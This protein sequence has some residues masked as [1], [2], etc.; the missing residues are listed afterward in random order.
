MTLQIAYGG[1]VSGESYFAR[2]DLEAELIRLLESSAGVKMFGLRRTGKS[3]LQLAAAKGMRKRGY[4]VVEIDAQGLRSND[5]LLRAVFK[6]LP[7][8][9]KSFSDK[10]CAFVEHNRAVSETGKKAF[11]LLLRKEA[12]PETEKDIAAYWEHY[13]NAI[14]Q[15]L[16]EAKPKLLLCIDELPFLLD[17]MLKDDPQ[18]G[19]RQVDQLLASLREW[20]GAGLKM[21]LAGSIGVA[22]LARTHNFRPD[23]LTDL[24]SLDMP[25]LSPGQAEEFVKQATENTPWTPDHTKALLLE[26]TV[27]YPSFLVKSLII[28]NPAAPSPPRDFPQKFAESIRPELYDAFLTQFDRRYRLYEQIGKDYRR[29]LVLPL[30]KAVFSSPDGI[31]ESDIALQHPFDQIDLR[32]A[33]NMLRED[34]FVRNSMDTEGKSFWKPGSGLASMWARKT[35][36]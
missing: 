1:P 16:K 27:L 7:E 2:P 22:A 21:L 29:N 26:L 25:E 23:H 24:S 18:H 34:G 11:E 33:L 36:L 4:T 30:L 12:G 20:R 31:R 10:V 8:Q 13:S 35:I 19:P 28:L 5:G 17:N 14:V 32:E 9:K 6:N 15:A 3:T